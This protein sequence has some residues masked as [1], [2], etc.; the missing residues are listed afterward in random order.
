MKAEHKLEDEAM[1]ELPQGAALPWE[2]RL[3]LEACER[4]ERDMERLRAEWGDKFD[5]REKMA[6]YAVRKFGIPLLDPYDK[7]AIE[8]LGKIEE[9]I[10]TYY[11]TRW[12]AGIGEKF[13]D[14]EQRLE[15][16]RG[17]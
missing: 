3:H 5:A 15:L 14:L 1:P 11:F 2:L 9:L 7:A 16:K 12:V 8:M 13:A 6:R 17:R 10:G 4:G